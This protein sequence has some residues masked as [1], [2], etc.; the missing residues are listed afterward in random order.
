MS[1]WR[2]VKRVQTPR[3]QW[4]VPGEMAIRE[5]PVSAKEKP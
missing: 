2:N 1:D 5:F 3:R 4:L